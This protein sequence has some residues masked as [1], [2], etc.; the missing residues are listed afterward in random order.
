LSAFD[1]S[2]SDTLGY[3]SQTL[4]YLLM[5]MVAVTT[6]AAFE[7]VGSIIVIA[8]LIVPAAT[9]LLLTRRLVAMIVIACI[10]GILSA[11]LGHL[12]ALT[13][14][15]WFGFEATTSSGMMAFAAGALF[16]AAWCFSPSEGQLV[17]WLH[18]QRGQRGIIPPPEITP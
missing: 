17:K 5:T 11:V 14:P 2:L 1:A 7:A 6:V 15:L 9:A 12:G 4:H 16:F 3:S 8:M 13:V 10:V 18:R